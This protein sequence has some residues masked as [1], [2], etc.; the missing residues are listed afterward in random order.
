MEARRFAVAVEVRPPAGGG[1][2]QVTA[3]VAGLRGRGVNLFSIAPSRSARPPSL[4]LKYPPR[5]AGPGDFD[6]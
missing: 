6:R 2:E 3:E 4:I 5:R 1:V